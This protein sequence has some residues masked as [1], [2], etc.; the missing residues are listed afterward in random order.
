MGAW[1]ASTTMAA[2]DTTRYDG[3]GQ[4]QFTSAFIVY[5]RWRIEGEASGDDLA[6][7]GVS[8]HAQMIFSRVPSSCVIRAVKINGE[9]E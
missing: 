9:V 4:L 5:H 6:K 7:S 2:R 1:P 8:T 3:W